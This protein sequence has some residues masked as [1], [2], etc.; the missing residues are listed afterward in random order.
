MTACF[1]IAGAVHDQGGAP[2][3]SDSSYADTKVTAPPNKCHDWYPVGGFLFEPGT[4][5]TDTSI[6]A[7]HTLT[8]RHG[9]IFITFSGTYDLVKT[10]VGS[11]SWVIT[12]G[13]GAYIGAHGEGTW[14]ADAAA[15]PYARHTET[16]TLTLP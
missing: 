3:W 13:T 12:G 6:Y 7:V 16:G 1:K 2:N 9:S 5:T 4:K 11:G 10:F 15:F 14:V 8:L